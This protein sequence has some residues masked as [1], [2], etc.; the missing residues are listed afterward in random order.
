MFCSNGKNGVKP[1]NAIV[2]LNTHTNLS[3]KAKAAPFPTTETFNS[4]CEWHL[5]L[6]VVGGGGSCRRQRQRE[7]KKK[8]QSEATIECILYYYGRTMTQICCAVVEWP[9]RIECDRMWLK[10]GDN[11]ISQDCYVRGHIVAGAVG[12]VAGIECAIQ[13]KHFY[14]TIDTSLTVPNFIFLCRQID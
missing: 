1:L 9:I 14:C 12:G 11:D 5:R 10:S 6:G 7:A 8:I 13:W 4:I 2:A 3:A